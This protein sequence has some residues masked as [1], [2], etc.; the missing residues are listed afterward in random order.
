MFSEFK[1]LYKLNQSRGN[2]ALGVLLLSKSPQ[3][4]GYV[5]LKF[6]GVVDLDKELAEYKLDDIYYFVGHTQAPTSAAQSFNHR[7][8]HPFTYGS[9][10]VA[11][12][13]ILTNFDKLKQD[14][15]VGRY[16]IVDSSI[17]PA[18]L[19]QRCTK[20]DDITSVTQVL[21]ELEGTHA[22]WIY[23]IQTQRLYISRCGSV[24]YANQDKC[25]FSSVPTE[26]MEELQDGTLYIKLDKICSVSKFK[27]NSPFYIV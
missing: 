6:E 26:D 5:T 8:S 12:N 11:H 19:H 17:I 18:M 2:A 10:I 16:N 3:C 4:V 22:T 25:V 7:T 13:G 1:E 15:P 14:V 24:L 9:W 27:N 20:S 21:G 23:N